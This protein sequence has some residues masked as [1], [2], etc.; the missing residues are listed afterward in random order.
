VGALHQGVG[1][2]VEDADRVAEAGFFDQSGDFRAQGGV[3]GRDFETQRGVRAAEARRG[4]EHR[5][6]KLVDFRRA[7]AGQERDQS[8]LARNLDAVGYEFIDQG[9]ADELRFGTGGGEQFG[10]RW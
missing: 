5:R 4:F 2:A 7:A 6:E 9:V 1:V 3:G 8:R 10:L